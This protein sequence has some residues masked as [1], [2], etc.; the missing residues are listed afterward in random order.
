[1]TKAEKAV[2]SMIKRIQDDPRVAYIIGP[3]TQTYDD[4]TD[5]Y[6]ELIGK[7]PDEFRQEF[8]STLKTQR[9]EPIAD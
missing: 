8:E 3:F 2:S 9:V 1:M 4:I 5:A 7:D 6:A